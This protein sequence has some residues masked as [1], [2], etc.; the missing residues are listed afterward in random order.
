[1]IGLDRSAPEIA[2]ELLTRGEGKEWDPLPR[3]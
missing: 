1:M 3:V 2:R